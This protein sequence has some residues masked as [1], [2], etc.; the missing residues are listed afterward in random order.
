MQS[1]KESNLRHFPN[2]R[3]L[4]IFPF[5]RLVSIHGT[6][7]G[8]S[9]PKALCAYSKSNDGFCEL[10]FIFSATVKPFHPQ[11]PSATQKEYHLTFIP[12]MCVMLE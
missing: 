10:V 7:E 11:H 12:K 6:I 9:G 4:P 5:P 2:L 8:F 3:V 1:L